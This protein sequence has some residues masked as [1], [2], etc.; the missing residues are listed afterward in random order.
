MNGFYTLRRKML[1]FQLLEQLEVDTWR[2]IGK[3]AR[4]RWPNEENGSASRDGA[5][6]AAAQCLRLEEGVGKPI[7]RVGPGSR[8]LRG[9]GK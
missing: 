1:E 5:A 4:V 2:R 3:S 6:T 8:F 7:A 9:L